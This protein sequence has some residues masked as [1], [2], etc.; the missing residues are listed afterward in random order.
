MEDGD[1][2]CSKC[3]KPV[4]GGNPKHSA[5]TREKEPANKLCCELAY[6][7]FL[8]WLPLAFYRKDKYAARS[9]NQ[10]LWALITSVVC[11]TVIRI[12]GAVNAFFSGNLIGVVT[13]GIYSLVFIAFLSFML[14][15]MWR[16]LRNV[17]NIH[18]GREMEPVL[19]F[20]EI[21]FFQ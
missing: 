8:F 1:S 9:A 11:C 4:K 14:Y 20:D 18:A 10:G 19:F 3:G 7:G 6:S 12:L 17:L 15:L 5:A 21:A 2:F 13:D 16:C